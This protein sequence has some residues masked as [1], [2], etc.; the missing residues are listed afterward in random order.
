ML[1]P[2]YRTGWAASASK[3][4][5]SSRLADT[6]HGSSRSSPPVTALCT[7]YQA[8]LTAHWLGPISGRA[9]ALVRAIHRKGIRGSDSG[10]NAG[11]P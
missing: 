10:W 7:A 5:R 9:R 1:A 2:R 3:P 8:A 4:G 6:E 11:A